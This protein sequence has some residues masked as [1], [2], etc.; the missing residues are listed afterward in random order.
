MVLLAIY[1]LSVTA[2]V[3]SFDPF[4]FEVKNANK[5]IH[6]LKLFDYGKKSINW[7]QDILSKLDMW[8]KQISMNPL[9]FEKL[10]K[11]N[12]QKKC[13]SSLKTRS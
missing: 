8:E 13:Q 4:M 6:Y 7:T 10:P 12:I 3:T 11:G 9:L 5:T 1:Y 2:S